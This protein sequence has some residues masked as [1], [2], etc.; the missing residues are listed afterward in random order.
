[1]TYSTIVR[2]TQYGYDI[3][4]LALPGCHSQGDSYEEAFENI[5]NAIVTYLGL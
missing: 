5:K 4:M 3:H 2:K 1:M